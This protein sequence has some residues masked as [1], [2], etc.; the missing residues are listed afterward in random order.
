MCL[1]NAIAAQMWSTVSDKDIGKWAQ[2]D[3]KTSRIACPLKCPF[4][5]YFLHVRNISQRSLQAESIVSPPLSCTASPAL[6][7]ML[8]PN[9]PVS[10][11]FEIEEECQ[12]VKRPTSNK[13]DAHV[14]TIPPPPHTLCAGNQGP[15]MGHTTQPHSHPR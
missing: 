7:L 11:S 9:Y 10:C 3:A 14:Y 2:I 1:C 6:L 4:V 8:T 15:N 5:L 13:M 12:H